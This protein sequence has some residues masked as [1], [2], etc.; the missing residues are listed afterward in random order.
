MLKEGLT[1]LKE[2]SLDTRLSRY[3]FKCRITPHTSTGTSPAEVVFGCQLQFLLDKVRP[4]SERT[5][6]YFTR[7][8]PRKNRTS[9]RGKHKA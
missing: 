2:G 5:A 3:L 9:I 8:K 1:K 7:Q 6:H 4:S